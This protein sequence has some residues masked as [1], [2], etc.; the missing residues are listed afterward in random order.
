MPTPSQSMTVDLPYVDVPTLAETVADQVRMV[1]FD[2]YSVRL[3]LAVARPYVTGP[4]QSSQ[5]LYPCARIVLSPI[6]A[7]V[8]HE[9]L[10]ALLSVLEQQG[11]LKRM[12]PTSGKKQ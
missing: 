2:G 5:A 4:N 12:A 3:E 8:L 1:H 11:T 6:S 10:G 9:Q 7:A